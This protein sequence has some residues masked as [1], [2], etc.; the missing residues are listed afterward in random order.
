M[1]VIPQH[2]FAEPWH[3]HSGSEV[4]AF[5]KGELQNALAAA[6]GKV[7]YVEMVG[8]DLRFYAQEGDQQP[9]SV[10]NLG[11]DIFSITIASDMPQVFYILADEAT[12]NITITPST[13][14]GSFG[15]QE[16]EDYP[17]TY[18]Y[19]VAFNNGSGYVTRITGSTE[20][21][22][23]SA[24]FDIRPFIS[25]GDNYVR[26][27]VTGQASG[28]TKS[29]V[30][31]ATLT[32][33]TLSVN[34]TWQT[35]WA[36]GEDYVLNG[37]RFAG[38]LVKTLHVAVDG[39]EQTPVE[40]Q[41]NQSYTTTATTYTIPRTAFPA[42]SGNG[43]HTVTLWMTAQGVSTPV[44]VL[45]I[46]C[47]ATDDTTPMVALN[48]VLP[49]VNYTS[50]TLLYY[51]V[52]NADS[53]EF[54]MSALLG[55]TT[56]EV[57]TTVVTGREEETQYPFS[58]ALEID[59]GTNNEKTG[60]LT[61]E[62]TPYSGSTAGEVHEVVTSFDNTYSYLA[63]AGALFYM[64]AATR[65]NGAADHENI[66][67]VMGAS[68]DGK[69]AASY[70]A[71]WSGFSWSG[72]AWATDPDGYKAL[73]V[74]AGSSV[75]VPT[76][77]PLSNFTYYNDGMT[78]EMMIRCGYPSDYDTPV[79]SLYSG[80][81]TPVGVIIYPTKIQVFGSTERST[82]YQS[83][84]LTENRMTHL[85][86][87]WV[88]NYENVADRNLVSIYVNGISN[89]NFSFSSQSLFGDG[90]LEIGQA[91]TDAYLYKMR[92]YGRA[93]DSQAIFNNF[94]NCI[95]D[96]VEFNRRETFLKNNILGGAGTPSYEDVKAA[97]FNIMVVTM[98]S[99]SSPIPSITNENTYKGCSLRFEYADDHTKDTTVQNVDLDG[100]G[101]TSKKY[102]RWNLRAK[103]NEDTIWIYG[104][105]D[106]WVGKAGWFAGV[107]NYTK[108]DRITAKKN[109]A[110][111]PQGHKMGMTGLYNDLFKECNLGSHLPDS[112][113]RV[114]VYQ[115]P[116]VGFRYYE[117]NQTYEYIGL[118]TAGP[119]KGSKVTFGYDKS[120]YPN[121]LSIEG[122]NHAP[123]GTRFLTPWVDVTYDPNDETLKYGGEEGW[124][125]DY[126]KWETSTK[127]T[128]TDWDNIYNLYV[129]EWKPAYEL[130]Y[131]CS[132]YIEKLQD[133]LTQGGYA[134][135]AAVNADVENFWKKSTNGISN[136]LLSFY[137]SNYDLV[138]YRNRTGA[139]D[140]LTA[141]EG[142][143]TFNVR[144]YA[145][146][147]GSPTTAQIKAARA[148]KFIAQAPNYWDMDQTLFHYAFCI[149]FGV[150]DNFAKNSY[151]FKF[152]LLNDS[153]AGNRWGWR[154]DDLDT[155]LATD[156]NGQS[157]KEYYVEH[158]D[159]V[160]GTDIFQGGSSALWV[161][162][163]DNYFTQVRDMMNLIANSANSLAVSL[164][165]QGNG[166]HESLFNVVSH[167]CWEQSAK[168]FSATLYETDKR[169]SYIEPWLLNPAQTY[170]GV[171]P[172]TQALGDQY[173]AERIWMERRIAY[174]FSK[175]SIGAFYGDVEGYNTISFTLAAPF[176]FRMTP[177]IALYPTGAMGS[178]TY[179]GDRTF[180]DSYD[181]LMVMNSGDTTNYIKGGD[182][183]SSLGPLNGMVLRSRGGS[184]DIPFL[185][186]AQRLQEL[187]VGDANPN[188]VDFNATIFGVSSMSITTIDAR[189]T[190]TITNPV[191]LLNCPRL[192]TALFEGSGA[193]GL[194][195]PVGAK[196]TEVSFPANAGMVF[197]HS[198]P[199][200]E[201]EDTT[202]PT[203]TNITSLYLNNNANFNP[204]AMLTT[205]LGTTGNQLTYATLIWN[206]VIPATMTQI[207]ALLEL[208]TKNGYV[209]YTGGEPTP[210]VGAPIVNGTLSY[211][212]TLE[213]NKYFQI[214]ETFDDVTF[215]VDETKV[216]I[217]FEDA[218]VERIALANW[219]TDS[220]GFISMG[221]ALAVT[222]I[223][224][225]FY[226]NTTI[227]TFDEFQYFTNV[228]S[229]SPMNVN[230]QGFSGCTNLTSIVLPK[231]LRML[232]QS[233][234]RNCS[235]LTSVNLE[236][237]TELYNYVFQGCTNLEIDVNM[238]YLTR[239]ND[240]AFIN[241]GITSV[242]S[243]GNTITS[244]QGGSGSGDG[245]FRGCVKLESVNLPSSVTE[246][247][248]NAFNGCTNLET[249]NLSSSILTIGAGAFQNC[250]NIETNVNLPNLVTLGNNAFYGSGIKKVLSLGNIT[251]IPGG[252]NSSGA[253][254]NCTR[255]ESVK[256]TTKLTDISGYA[257]YGCS[258][259]S[260]IDLSEVTTIG[261]AA[262]YGALSGYE[263]NAPNL[264][265]LGQQAFRTSGLT[266]I[267]NLGRVTTLTADSS[268]SNGGL[269]ARSTSLTEVTLPSTLTTINR[270]AFYSCSA[271]QK[272][273]IL[274][275]TPPSLANTD[276]FSGASVSLKFY[277][278]DTSIA[279]YQRATNWR[280]YK[281]KIFG[282]N[283]G[284]VTYNYGTVTSG[285]YLK[286]NDSQAADANYSISDYISVTPGHSL[287]FSLGI[288][289]GTAC[290]NTYTSSKA[291]SDYWGGNATPRTFT[292]GA[293]EVYVRLSILNSAMATGDAYVFDNTSGQLLYP[294]AIVTYPNNDN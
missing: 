224:N 88:K 86:I 83:V 123:R 228:P 277:V 220:S 134:N 8:T 95:I 186:T 241:S 48:R 250:T 117:T 233:S 211:D 232:G 98:N 102:F 50:G 187:K 155:V 149:L 252:T 71:T 279:D 197:M 160:D 92:V 165:I 271:L 17:E 253:F 166:M 147:T 111:S 268:G 273:T 236:N 215:I 116:F 4:E 91:N 159:T 53:V 52:F 112:K 146:L 288:V 255:L 199:F 198:L 196:I 231:S 157:T 37:I 287:S 142:K 167:Y 67:N 32:T 216:Y 181:D 285:Y 121:C 248:Q 31:T 266:K 12:K 63:T 221:E 156:N 195:L 7:G 16:T 208:S 292:L 278:P 256:T 245:T 1:S 151:P 61:I 122:P 57:G 230:T 78:L 74:P 28:Q 76:F 284:Q 96:G 172:L 240:T 247:G 80:G 227:E 210:K 222:N 109:Y 161:L 69:F 201:P 39:V 113:C 10:I 276:A 77:A 238:P 163:R 90:N 246:I 132:P 55:Q 184:T 269:F 148:A 104:N 207:D 162:I 135:I 274:A 20:H 87:T 280:T 137:D 27:T 131:H 42:S 2:D 140:T 65:D 251:T 64:N 139:Y 177:A 120:L 261:N 173:Q 182:W 45:N 5:I 229:L 194:T 270:Y 62:A 191:S 59:T 14:K 179:R 237:V 180:P 262:F 205:I 18:L 202:L 73:V 75:S 105:G 190:T 259:L 36:E 178:T 70:P 107:D 44:T 125:C 81:N 214:T 282:I 217:D 254:Q 3:G 206:D 89:C 257:F 68:G 66:V 72:D 40:Y 34:H 6:D 30:Y 60:T 11:G 204:L 33:L 9:I 97:G 56:Y 26:V 209:E 152:R 29:L 118:Y 219:D 21:P 235:S 244:I 85:A 188:N 100:Q 289:N 138:F 168:Y 94:L 79:F 272:V 291:F 38:N 164:N 110:S 226:N 129:S 127:G 265:T 46:M 115:L 267:V 258:A 103:T 200:L 101:T 239:L 154:Q 293:N 263:L 130:V 49:A 185:V 108:V 260:E 143:S 286:N 234:F 189:N 183:L 203:I 145:G 153:G 93:L 223:T 290:L 144:T 281:S 82:T 174:I 19:S 249:I 25:N 114:A 35:I 58:Y 176:T 150:T 175:Y 283:G 43:V 243:L 47:V 99:D 158:G 169:W 136:Q 128:Q 119:D 170:N 275:T 51:A 218:E 193:T 106:S 126:V 294:T 171:L 84:N 264:E 212:G 15:S 133:A 124:D 24:T 242:T 225:L 141:A 213:L 54:D 192:T 22:H 13:A 23:D 41:P